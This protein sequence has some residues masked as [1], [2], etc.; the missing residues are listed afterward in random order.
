MPIMNKLTSAYLAG[1][2]DGEGSIDFQKT[3]EPQCV[4]GYH[5][6][7]RLRVGMIDREFIE[8]L[9][10]SF[11]GGIYHR[12]G[13]GRNKDSYCWNVSGK[14]MKEIIRCVYP[15][16]RIKKEHANI[17]IKF[18]KTKKYI[19]MNDHKELSP[20][21][22]IERDNLFRQLKLLQIKGISCTVRD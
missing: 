13:N 12:I 2:I 8:W 14:I 7:P 4:A 16:L 1:I 21:M 22:R 15:Y 17:M 18:W 5:Y 10:N 19:P 20:E 9:K 11:G 6:N 3:K